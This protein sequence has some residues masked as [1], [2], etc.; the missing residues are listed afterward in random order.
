MRQLGL[1]AIKVC[2]KL[3]IGVKFWRMATTLS[4]R[5]TNYIY[6]FL[7]L[8]LLLCTG[9]W[10]RM[11]VLYFAHKCKAHSTP[12]NKTSSQCFS[13]VIQLLAWTYVTGVN[14]LCLSLGCGLV[15][16]SCSAVSRNVVLSSLFRIH[17]RFII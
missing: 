8:N 14:V 16:L 4:S 5:K 17:G 1:T 3:I 11:T 10:Y 2:C 7:V 13:A 12:F 15:P 6:S 9:P